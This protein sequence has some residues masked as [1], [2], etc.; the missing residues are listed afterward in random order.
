MFRCVRA[1]SSQVVK[2]GKVGCEVAARDFESIEQDKMDTEI[3]PCTSMSCTKQY[4]MTRTGRWEKGGGSEWNLCA[5]QSYV[6]VWTAQVDC[7]L[8]GRCRF[9]G[10]QG[11]GSY[12]RPVQIDR[13]AVSMTEAGHPKLQGRDWEKKAKVDRVW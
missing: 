4:A 2:V 7:Q 1:C 13:D 12:S 10:Q 11:A 6:S 3:W 5:S 9:A 8:P